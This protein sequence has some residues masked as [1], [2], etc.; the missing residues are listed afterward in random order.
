MTIEELR[1]LREDNP[2]AYKSNIP[3]VVVNNDRPS[4]P[5]VWQNGCPPPGR[6][7]KPVEDAE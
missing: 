1:K 3:R 4:S 5:G 7:I 2:D 6:V